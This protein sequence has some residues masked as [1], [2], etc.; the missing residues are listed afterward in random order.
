MNVLNGGK[1]M[2][3]KKA[4]YVELVKLAEGSAFEIEGEDIEF[5]IDQ[6]L[7]D[8][9]GLCDDNKKIPGVAKLILKEKLKN[10]YHTRISYP[11]LQKK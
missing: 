1:R 5:Y 7:K 11:E 4:L 2:E 10:I 3:I 6:Y 9:K 8:Y